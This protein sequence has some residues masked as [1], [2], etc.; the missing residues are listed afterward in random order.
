MVLDAKNSVMRKILVESMSEDHVAVIEKLSKPRYDEDIAEESKMKATIV[1]TL[2]NELHANSLVEYER[3]KNK[4]TG[5][6]TYLWKKREDK[7]EEHVT[8]YLK[9]KLDELN[10]RLEDEQGGIKFTCSCNRVLLD[11]ALETNFVCPDCCQQYTEYDNSEEVDKLVSEIARVNS[12]L[13]QT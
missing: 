6:Y 2:L 13:E 5:W 3:S 1:R 9:Q 10:K 8:N 4:K 11:A 12:L 7:I